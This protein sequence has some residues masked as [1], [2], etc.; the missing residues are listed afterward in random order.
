MSANPLLGRSSSV[1]ST[2]GYPTASAVNGN[3]SGIGGIQISQPTPEHAGYGFAGGIT[4][5]SSASPIGSETALSAGADH[6]DDRDVPPEI[7]ILS[8]LPHHQNLIQYL[9][10]W[11]DDVFYYLVL[12]LAGPQVAWSEAAADHAWN[13]E[14][15]ARG[16]TS[17]DEMDGVGESGMLPPL[18]LWKTSRDLFEC[19]D[20]FGPFCEDRARLVFRQLVDIVEFLHAHN[21]CHR[22]LKDENIL[23]N[24]RLEVKLIDFGSAAEGFLSHGA[25]PNGVTSPAY[26]SAAPSSA[27]AC[28]LCYDGSKAELYAL[29]VLLYVMLNVEAPYDDPD[30]ALR[31]P[32]KP[33][34]RRISEQAKLVIS[35]LMQRDPNRR[36]SI[37]DVRG[38][39]WMKAGSVHKPAL[40]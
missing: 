24:D 5:T 17:L 3:G 1:G 12:E 22:D 18:P 11:R 28:N 29:G 26:G 9:H 34:Q 14:A 2:S 25:P 33:Y 31:M 30:D 13:S 10:H 7:A 32:P 19:L 8:M 23:V 37:A 27:V 16:L 40:V 6:H 38:A 20:R 21:V 15:P 35:R 39:P 36:W 4:R